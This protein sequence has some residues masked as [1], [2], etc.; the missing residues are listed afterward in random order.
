RDSLLMGLGMAVLA[1]TRPYE[2]MIVSV[3]SIGMLF[4]MIIGSPGR[5]WGVALRRI[6]SPAA[7]VLALTFAWIGYFNL[8]VTGPILP[9][10]E[11][12]GKKQYAQAPIFFWQHPNAVT[13]YNHRE[14]QNFYANWEMDPYKRQQ[15]FKGLASEVKRKLRFLLKGEPYRPGYNPWSVLKI[16]V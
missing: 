6:A 8:P 7:L 13:Q 1:N 15:S 4:T 12:L 14:M 3:L 16:S 2:G 5:E 11:L 9:M 10:P